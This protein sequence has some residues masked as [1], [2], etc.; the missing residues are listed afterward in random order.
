MTDS[1]LQVARHDRIV[2]LCLNRPRSKNALNRELVLELGR[3]LAEVSAQTDVRAVI[4]T[5]AGQSFCSGADLK[6]VTQDP[7]VDM[8]ERIDE[9]HALIRTIVHAPMPFVAAV[10]GPAVGFGADLALSCDLRVM[11]TRAYLQEKF[12][13]IG[14]MPDGGGTFWLPRL[15]GHG[16]AMELLL[17]GSKIDAGLALH[18]GL[19]NRVVEPES[20]TKTANDLAA[21]LAKGPP[22][23]L[24]QIRRSV[25]ES[26]RGTVEDALEREKEGQLRLLAS[27]DLMEGVLAWSERRPPEFRGK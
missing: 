16:R 22:L 18:L 7:D 17:F 19:C 6:A 1:P 26:Y 27:E 4:L 3:V 23:A 11:T 14:L 9:F 8:A 13:N 5:G 12:V 2:T 20:L 15:V 24:A 21:T 10:D 25:R